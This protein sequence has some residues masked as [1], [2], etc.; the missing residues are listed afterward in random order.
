MSVE[1]IYEI[2]EDIWVNHKNKT[3]KYKHGV[4]KIYIL[5]KEHYIAHKMS[6]HSN[7]ILLRKDNFL[8]IKVS[9]QNQMKIFK[10]L[11]SFWHSR[12]NKMPKINHRYYPCKNIERRR[13]EA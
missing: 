1:E 8:V 2:K 4:Y 3:V 10:N 7:N 6:E 5:F 12:N 11:F 9:R 13:R